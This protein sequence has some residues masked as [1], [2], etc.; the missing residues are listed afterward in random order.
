MRRPARCGR[1]R[2]W[3]DADR[4]KLQEQAQIELPVHLVSVR[5][6]DAALCDHWF[7]GELQPLLARHK[8]LAAAALKRKIGGLRAAVAGALQR[9]L[10]PQDKAESPEAEPAL[11]ALRDGETLLEAAERNARDAGRDMTKLVASILDSVAQRA[12]DG[13]VSA[14]FTAAASAEIA[15]ATS[16]LWRQLDELRSR[17]MVAL[18]SA[19]IGTG[20]NAFDD[21]PGL[22]ELPG[23]DLAPVIAGLNGGRFPVTAR[24]NAGLRRRWL[25][26]RVKPELSGALDRYGQRLRHWA[27]ETVGGLQEA[28][29]ARTG[30]CR[31]QLDVTGD[32]DA[33]SVAEDVRRLEQWG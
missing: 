6:A 21:L 20:A 8:E 28:F 22:T 32:V 29:T 2:A 18:Q 17:L 11:Q 3:A 23:M 10:Q 30:V 7:A 33:L 9:R 16:A 14:S 13:D 24:W 5:G 26:Q 27:R 12:R 15:N 31:A 1:C 25:R 4:R 19:E